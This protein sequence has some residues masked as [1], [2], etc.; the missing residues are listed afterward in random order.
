MRQQPQFSAQTTTASVA[1]CQQSASARRK[2]CHSGQ[3]ITQCCSPSCRTS[4]PTAM[5]HNGAMLAPQGESAWVGTGCAAALAVHGTARVGPHLNGGRARRHA[6]CVGATR[7]RPPARNLKGLRCSGACCLTATLRVY[8][9]KQP[10]R[11]ASRGLS[12]GTQPG[13]DIIPRSPAHT[14]VHM[15]A[16]VQSADP[17]SLELKTSCKCADAMCCALIMLTLR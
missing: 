7:R 11:F 1:C 6:G 17:S 14:S 2:E 13:G 10:L 3:T 12:I 8:V 5:E 15:I 9:S 4:A 16:S